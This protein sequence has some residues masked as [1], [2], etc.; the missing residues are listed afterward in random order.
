MIP[1]T[2]SIELF[3]FQTRQL[4]VAEFQDIDASL[5]H[6]QFPDKVKVEWPTPRSGNQWELTSLGWVGFIPLH[7]SKGLHL[8]PKV[9]L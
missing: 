9:P 1:V 6:S 4:A 2:E 5:L 8:R 7:G 3:E